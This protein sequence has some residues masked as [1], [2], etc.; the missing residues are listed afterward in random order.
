MEPEIQGYVSD[1]SIL[2]AEMT[3][4][5]AKWSKSKRNRIS[6]RPRKTSKK[7]TEKA[8]KEIEKTGDDF[9]KNLPLLQTHQEQT[10][11]ELS[12]LIENYSTASNSPNGDCS[13]SN[14][15]RQQKLSDLEANILDQVKLFNAGMKEMVGL[16][17]DKSYC[18]NPVENSISHQS[19]KHSPEN[20]A[21]I[22]QPNQQNAG[23]EF[24]ENFLGDFQEGEKEIVGESIN[25][26]N[27]ESWKSH[28][29]NEGKSSFGGNFWGHQNPIFEDKT[30]LAC[31]NYQSPMTEASNR[32]TMNQELLQKTSQRSQDEKGEY[33]NE[34][35]HHNSSRKRKIAEEDICLEEL[36]KNIQ[37]DI[38]EGI[39][40]EANSDANSDNDSSISCPAEIECLRNLLENEEDVQDDSKIAD[41]IYTSDVEDPEDCLESHEI[42]DHE[43]NKETQRQ[44]QTTPEM[45]EFEGEKEALVNIP[46]VSE[47]SICIDFEYPLEWD[48]FD[49]VNYKY[50]TANERHLH[51]FYVVGPI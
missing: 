51:S 12:A 19:G 5:I 10:A 45:Q 32:M 8:A 44:D 28:L 18:E 43:S 39:L 14:A 35:G 1:G 11:E 27:K 40:L 17:T 7:Y 47:K 38:I 22:S 42:Q 33:L 2:D 49:P 20:N 6:K 9:H 23:H 16:I 37:R 36:D 4:N 3:S 31:E 24:L 29:L 25:G 13:Q 26:E 46:R 15:E 48:S 30:S 50:Y 34:T 21:G 41:H